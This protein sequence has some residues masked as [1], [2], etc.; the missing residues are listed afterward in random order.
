[1]YQRERR[2]RERER[3]RKNERKTGGKDWWINK[4]P[5]LNR[6]EKGRQ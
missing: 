3:E 5:L 6:V 2:E 4:H 1:M